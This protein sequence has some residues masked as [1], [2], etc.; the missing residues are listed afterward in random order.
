VAV[1]HILPYFNNNNNNKNKNNKFPTLTLLLYTESNF[2]S[3]LANVLMYSVQFAPKIINWWFYRSDT[4][5]VLL[6]MDNVDSKK[7]LTV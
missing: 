5:C 3:L 1:I 7:C 6:E 2:F 4:K